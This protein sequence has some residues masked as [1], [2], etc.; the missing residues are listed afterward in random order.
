MQF[1]LNID[2]DNLVE[3]FVDFVTTF[4]ELIFVDFFGT[5]INTAGALLFSESAFWHN[6]IMMLILVIL[7]ALFLADRR[8]G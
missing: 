2:I 7:F 4:L 1:D 5:I 3:A 6:S 8:F